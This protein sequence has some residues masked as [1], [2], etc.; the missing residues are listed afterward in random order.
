[1]ADRAVPIELRRFLTLILLVHGALSHRYVLGHAH[2]LARSASVHGDDVL[3]CPYPVFHWDATIGTIAP[4]LW[5]GATAVVTERFSVSRF[6]ADVRRYGG[7][8]DRIHNLM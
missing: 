8:S 3:F 6:W 7:G 4:A 1:M 5:T 2:L